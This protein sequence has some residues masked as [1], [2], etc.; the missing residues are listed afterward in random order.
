VLTLNRFS[1]CGFFLVPAS[2]AAAA[3]SAVSSDA[4]VLIL[5]GPT[6]VITPEKQ[7]SGAMLAELTTGVQKKLVIIHRLLGGSTLHFRNENCVRIEDPLQLYQASVVYFTNDETGGRIEGRQLFSQDVIIEASA[8]L[9][10]SLKF[11]YASG[12]TY[13]FRNEASFVYWS[14]N[15]DKLQVAKAKLS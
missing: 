2:A 1:V 3:S 6:V 15:T 9:Y 7:A 12:R 8:A 14:G 11:I 5:A 4:G 10:N 13:E